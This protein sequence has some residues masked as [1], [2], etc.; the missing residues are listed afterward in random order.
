MRA[1][2]LTE[3]AELVP[4]RKRGIS[5]PRNDVRE[6]ASATFVRPVMTEEWGVKKNRVDPFYVKN[7]SGSNSLNKV[8]SSLATG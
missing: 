1:A 2:I 6:R 8:T 3:I 5:V 7:P 4:K